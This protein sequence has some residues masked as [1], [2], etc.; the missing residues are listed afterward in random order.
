M[1]GQKEDPVKASYWFLKSAESGYLEGMKNHAIALKDGI[2][3]KS[4]PAASLRWYLI[5]WKGGLRSPDMEGIMDGLKKQFSAAQIKAT[6]EA[7]D[8]WLAN[9][10]ARGR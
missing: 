5:A 8:K 4:Y 2:G 3:Q 1:F 6:E 9:F 7:A 10:A